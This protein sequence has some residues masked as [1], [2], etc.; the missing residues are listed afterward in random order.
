M[1][2]PSGSEHAATGPPDR[3]ILRLLEGICA[4]EPVVAATEF[5]PDSYEP[6]ILRILCDESQ[7]PSTTEAA[8]L[9]VRWFTSSDFSLQYVETMATDHWECRWD[10]HPNPHNARLHFHQPPSGDDITD[11]TW[12]SL[13]PIDVLSTVI[14]AIERRIEQQWS[15]NE[16]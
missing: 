10:R 14:A 9:D 16:S 1:T 7:Y 13:H 11:L 15:T 6:R 3:Q 2:P 5:E 12:S 4:N 8:R